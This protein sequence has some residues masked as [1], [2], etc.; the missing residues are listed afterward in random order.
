MELGLIQYLR[1]QF[2]KIVQGAAYGL[3]FLL[4]HQQGGSIPDNFKCQSCSTLLEIPNPSLGQSLKQRILKSILSQFVFQS[5]P[6]SHGYSDSLIKDQV[7]LTFSN[8]FRHL[9][10]SQLSY[11]LFFLFRIIIFINFNCMVFLLMSWELQILAKFFIIL[12]C[13]LK[14][15]T[16]SLLRL[17]FLYGLF[18]I[19]ITALSP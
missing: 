19:F 13:F 9:L 3:H 15:R 1:L 11:R 8:L 4:I 10:F 2:C 5:R 17:S 16:H 6:N 7:I 14:W 12:A 18:L